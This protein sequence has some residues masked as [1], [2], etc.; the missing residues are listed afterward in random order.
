M[1]TYF[2]QAFTHVATK[3]AGRCYRGQIGRGEKQWHIISHPAIHKTG[4]RES[5]LLIEILKLNRLPLTS[6]LL[7]KTLPCLLVHIILQPRLSPTGF[8][9]ATSF[10]LSSASCQPKL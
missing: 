10:P 1:V 8:N 9:P 2:N 6:P 5:L 7:Y 4:M 3:N